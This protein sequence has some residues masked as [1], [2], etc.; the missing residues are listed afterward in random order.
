[1]GSPLK[2]S[3]FVVFGIRFVFVR[4]SSSNFLKDASSH[5][6]EQPAFDQPV[7]LQCG[8]CKHLHLLYFT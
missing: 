6:W 5:P 1:M 7:S 4:A 2:L 3:R 8:S